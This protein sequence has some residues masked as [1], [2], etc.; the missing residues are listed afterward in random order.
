LF[1]KCGGLPPYKHIPPSLKQISI[2]RKRFKHIVV[3]LKVLPLGSRVI[4]FGHPFRFGY[5]K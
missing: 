4:I 1:A 5:G 3:R 2:T